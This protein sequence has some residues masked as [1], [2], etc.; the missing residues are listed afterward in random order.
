MA[1]L[2]L[3]L[4]DEKRDTLK[5]EAKRNGMKFYP[6]VEIEL[7]KLADK[8]EKKNEQGRD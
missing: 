6:Y 8:L 4:P 5:K 3:Q 1:Y 7:I 2:N